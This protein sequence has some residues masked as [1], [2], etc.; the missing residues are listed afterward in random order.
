MLTKYASGSIWRPA[1]RRRS[2]SSMKLDRLAAS[3]SPS[4]KS[5][6]IERSSHQFA[7]PQLETNSSYRDSWIPVLD[8]EGDLPPE[9]SHAQKVP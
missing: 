8:V 5:V 3:W 6:R 7:H 2:T 4:P 1:F 9:P